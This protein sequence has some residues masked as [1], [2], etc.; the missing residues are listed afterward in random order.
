[1][2]YQIF[3]NKITKE[4]EKQKRSRKD[5]FIFF[6]EKTENYFTCK[7]KNKLIAKGKTENEVIKKIMEVFKLDKKES[8]LFFIDDI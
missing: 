4:L 1:M 6:I 8:V 7:V 5:S 3:K 2:N